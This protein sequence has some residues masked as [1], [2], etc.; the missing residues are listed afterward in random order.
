MQR[1][2]A[3]D[4]LFNL[5]DLPPEMIEYI[6][7]FLLSA[8]DK[9]K[10]NTPLSRLSLSQSGIK[11]LAQMAEVNKAMKFYT[12]DIWQANFFMPRASILRN[13]QSTWLTDYCNKLILM[14]SKP[15]RIKV[16]VLTNCRLAFK[17]TGFDLI[18]TSLN[19]DATRNFLNIIT[20][21]FDELKKLMIEIIKQR[22]NKIYTGPIT[23]IRHWDKLIKPH[24]SFLTPERYYIREINLHMPLLDFFAFLFLLPKFHQ[25]AYNKTRGLIKQFDM[26]EI[27]FLNLY[28]ELSQPN[29]YLVGEH[30][31]IN[32]L[33][34]HR[35]YKFDSLII[36]SLE[37]YLTKAISNKLLYQDE[38]ALLKSINFKYNKNNDFTLDV[39]YYI[40]YQCKFNTVN[41]IGID[42]IE[43]YL[44]KNGYQSLN[45]IKNYLTLPSKKQTKHK[46][47]IA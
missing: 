10:N 1:I 3:E 8:H 33:N 46:C 18:F 15:N 37:N 43:K 47:A 30:N 31:I 5:M 12:D 21:L 26:L 20:P 4:P 6:L 14:L 38:D 29:I 44:C 25:L 9:D 19:I 45:T 40:P 36:H 41:I 39:I 24:L 2:S 13:H 32:K 28:T 11:D 17:S 34:F 27:E 35:K 16:N 7:S 22:P 42:N 23:Q